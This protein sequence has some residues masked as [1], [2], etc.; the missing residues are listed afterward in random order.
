MP[1]ESLRFLN[2]LFRQTSS[3]RL[4][5]SP[6][7]L[8]VSPTDVHLACDLNA[9]WHSRLPKIDWSNVVRNSDYICFKAV[10]D[11]VIYAVA[12]WSSPVAANRMKDAKSI[13]ELRRFAI[14]PDAPRNTATFVLAKMEK[15]IKAKLPHIALLISY[16][17]QE[18]HLGTIYKAANWT[19]A[20]EH[21][22]WN[23]NVASRKRNR[24]QSQSAKTKWIKWIREKTASRLSEADET[25]PCNGQAEMRRGKKGDP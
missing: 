16:Q 20:G 25:R 6:R 2:T 9:V 24:A 12:I 11:D 18:V 1:S 22:N 19:Q 3:Y 17:D 7:E 8:D 13:L 15:H 5:N 23:W 4:P 21:K 10:C 14:A